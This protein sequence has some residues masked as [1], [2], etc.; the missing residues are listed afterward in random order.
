MDKKKYES[1]FLFLLTERGNKPTTIFM[2]NRKSVT[3]LVKLITLSSTDF[4]IY[5]DEIAWQQVSLMTVTMAP[6]LCGIKRQVEC[7]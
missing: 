5:L 2:I 6:E 3:S 1:A 7:K 4:T